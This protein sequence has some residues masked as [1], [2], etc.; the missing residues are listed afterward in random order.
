[1][2][3]TENGNRTMWMMVKVDTYGTLEQAEKTR[4]HFQKEV[5]L[6]GFNVDII[7]TLHSDDPTYSCR[8]A[9]K[10]KLGK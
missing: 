2:R 8:L 4:K 6:Q 5:E 9:K 3:D 7:E 1:M 10:R